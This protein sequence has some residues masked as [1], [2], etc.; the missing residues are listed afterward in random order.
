MAGLKIWANEYGGIATFL[1][2]IVVVL[3]N[4]TMAGYVY[5]QFSKSLDVMQK[6]QNDQTQTLANVV[7]NVNAL[8]VNVGKLTD[9]M[10]D[11]EVEHIQLM[12]KNHLLPH[13][14]QEVK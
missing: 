6:G 9:R 10:N 2:V 8:T 4:L 11:W 3:I 5:G 13:R 12:K 1:G 14:W 7:S